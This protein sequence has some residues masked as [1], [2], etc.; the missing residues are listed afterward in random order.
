M[1]QGLDGLRAVA[2]LLVLTW[3]TSILGCGWLGVTL[4]F[5]LSGYLLTPILVQ[6]RDDLGTRLFRAFYGRRALRIFPVYYAYLLLMG[7]TTYLLINQFDWRPFEFVSYQGQTL[8]AATY[9]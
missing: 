9:S 8:Y 3:H 6:M 4:F 1:I 5:V 2:F 7:V